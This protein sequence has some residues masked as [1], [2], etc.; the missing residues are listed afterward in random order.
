MPMPENLFVTRHGESEGN[1][2]YRLSKKGDDSLFTDEFRRKP[3]EHW[4]LTERGLREDV[5]AA[6]AWLLKN[7]FT[8]FESRF[9]S[10]YV[11]TVQTARGLG[12]S[13]EWQEDY[14][15]RERNTGLI[16]AR[17]L[18]PHE[19][20]ALYPEEFALLEKDRLHGKPTAGESLMDVCDRVGTSLTSIFTGCRG[21]NVILV[22]HLQTML[23]I[24]FHTC[25]L[26]KRQLEEAADKSHLRY[27]KIGNCRI[28]HYTRR[29]PYN[30]GLTEDF[31]HWRSICPLTEP[32][33]DWEAIP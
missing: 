5:P 15:L 12:L 20:R 6:A 26:S 9:M 32:D 1:L 19:G 21:G 28:F 30:G 22:S 17:S 18:P 13:G 4:E 14:G 7:G 11:R 31:S 29:N 8:E 23:G 10:P 24:H 33:P 3:H 27:A 16:T 2:A 25:R